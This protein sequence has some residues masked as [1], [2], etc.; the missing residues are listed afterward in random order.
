MSKDTHKLMLNHSQAKVQLYGRYLAKYINII[1]RDGYTTHIHLYDLFSGEGIYDGGEKGSPII[2][3]DAVKKFYG[4]AAGAAPFINFTF[5]DI[6]TDVVAKLNEALSK[7]YKPQKSKIR[8]SNDNYLNL[9]RKVNDEVAAFKNE[10]AVIFLDPKGYKEISIAHIKELLSN[11]KSEV[12]VFLPIRDMY[13]FANMSNEE[14]NAGHEPLH[15]FISEV[16]PTGAPKFESQ[17]DFIHKIKNG[18][19]R[20]LLNYFVD[21]FSLEREP[22]HFFCLFFFTSHILGFEKMLETKWELDTEQGRGLKYEKSGMLFSG[23][24]MQDFPNDLKRFIQSERK[25]NSE[26]YAY[27]LHQGFLTKHTNEILR[28]WLQ[29][30]ELQVFN[31]DG[32]VGRKGAF[33]LT[34]DSFKNDPFKIYFQIKQNPIL[35]LF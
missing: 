5:N 8:V 14:R 20:V 22:G 27:S 34:Y 21:T 19:K 29:K 3:L 2:A 4:S 35:K 25:H 23:T 1:S 33:Y 10:K 6:D 12:L 17:L 24:E 9:L 11:N 18:L 7:E 13:R 16:F 26:L 28:D 32:T 30:D 31:S 15:K